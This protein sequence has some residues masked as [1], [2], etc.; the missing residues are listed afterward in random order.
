MA[1]SNLPDQKTYDTTRDYENLVGGLGALTNKVQGLD[2]K[3]LQDIEDEI[4]R[5]TETLQHRYDQPNWWK[6]AAGFAKPQLGGFLASAGSAAQAMGENTEL[7]R[8][9]MMPLAQLAVSGK[10]VGALAG[11][12]E[13]QKAL[14]NDALANGSIKDPKV[15]QQIIS[16]GYDSDIGKTAAK[17]LDLSLI[18]I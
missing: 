3:A 9:Q 10:V 2:T 16:M 7:Q 15:L 8:Q 5:Q 11:R 14:Y 4:K 18:H 1:D 6:V 17:M 13:K 12:S